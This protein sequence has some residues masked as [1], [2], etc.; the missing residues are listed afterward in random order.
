MIMK[1]FVEELI[2]KKRKRYQDDYNEML[3]DYNRELETIKGYNGRQI[4]ELLQNCDD[5]GSDEILISLDKEAQTISISNNGQPFSQKGYRS[6]FI[7]NLSSKTSKRKYIGNKGLGFRSIINWSDSIEI[8]SANL[9]LK[10]S[11]EN[12]V[13]V[14][15]EL[16]TED[17]RQAKNE[18]ENLKG[19]I[20]PIPFLSIPELQTVESDYYITTIKIKYKSEYLVDIIEQVKTI[21]PETLLFLRNIKYVKRQG[22]DGLNDIQCEKQSL[23]TDEQFKPSQKITFVES[24]VWNIFE[25]EAILP[26]QYKESNNDEDEFY[27]IKIA[28]E[29]NF[30]RTS[31]LLYSYFPTNIRLNQPYILHATFDLDSTRNQLND[32]NKNRFLLARIV[33]FT[34]KVAKFY[35]S[36]VV[37]YTPLEIL[38]HSHQADSLSKLGYY[39]KLKIAISEGCIYPCIDNTYKKKN[40]VIYVSDDFAQTLININATHLFSNHLKRLNSSKVIIPKTNLGAIPNIIDVLNKI[41]SL[42]LTHKH[43]ALFISQ[44]VKEGSFIK[45]RLINQLNLLVNDNNDIILGDEYIY[46]PITQGNELQTPSFSRIQFLNKDLYEELLVVFNYSSKDNP[47]R[48][49]FL[50]DKLSG[51][52]NIHSY[53]PATLAQKIVSETNKIIEK[54]ENNAIEKIQEMN[55]CLFYNYKKRDGNIPVMNER[56]NVPSITLNKKVKPINDLVLSSGYPTGRIT[57]LIFENIY[58]EENYIADSETLG[59]TQ[60]DDVY[61]IENYL[62]WLNVNRYAKYRVYTNVISGYSNYA[63]YIKQLKGLNQTSYSLTL[64]VIDSFYKVLEKISLE[65]LIIWI[66]FDE[67][68]KKQLNDL[69]NEDVFNN[70]YR[71]YNRISNIPTYLKYLIQS[72]YKYKFSDLLIDDDYLWS[73]DFNITYQSKEFTDNGINK[74]S[75]NEILVSLGAKDDFNQLTINKVAEIINKA[76][77]H[78]PDGKKTQSIYKKS[79]SHY[80]ENRQALVSPVELFADNGSEKLGLYAQDKVYFS[81]KIKLP[82]L[83]KKDFPIFNFPARQGGIEAIKF[84]GINDLKNLDI[85]ITTKTE[86]ERITAIF[87]EYFEKIKPL[88]LTQRISSIED[89]KQKGN[90]ANVCKNINIVLCESIT[91][92]V[93]D[94]EYGV[95]DYEFLHY[96][97]NEYYLRIKNSDT[98]DSLRKNHLFTE[99]FAEIISLSFDISGEKNEFK[100]ILQSDYEFAIENIKNEFGNDCYQEARNLLGLANHKQ[101]FWQAVFKSKEFEYEETLDDLSLEALIL[102][103]FNIEF[104]TNSIDYE[105]LED[106]TELNKVYDLFNLVQIEL[107]S[108]AS[109]YEYPIGFEKVNYFKIKNYLLSKKKTVKCSVW[110]Q[111]ESKEVEEQSLFLDLIDKYENFEGFVKEKSLLTKYEFTIDLDTILKE[112]VSFLYKDLQLSQEIDLDIVK[113]LNQEGLK[114]DELFQINQ[115]KRFKSLIYFKNAIEIIKQ[116]IRKELDEKIETSEIQVVKNESIVHPKLLDSVNLQPKIISKDYNLNKKN[117]VYIPKYVDTRKLKEIGTTSERIVYQYLLKD[118]NYKDV[119]WAGEDDEGLHHDIRY[120]DNSQRIK[121]VEV[122]TFDNGYFYLSKAEYEFGKNHKEDYEI[123]LV[124]N[125]QEIIPIRN[126]FTDGKYEAT[127]NEYI[128]Y[129]EY[130]TA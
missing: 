45:N 14:Y 35:A 89:K 4:L 9:L 82:K 123:W 37:N 33:D 111:L 34:T 66:Y 117:G 16:F 93:K 49:R 55:R 2:I 5:E 42:S 85:E 125:K 58:S 97:K 116:E 43:R 1:N 87:K 27:Q 31:P 119:Y 70:F 109:I 98:L 22:F 83:L 63:N 28:I 100:H 39:E 88:I 7:A 107:K 114:T 79:L 101:A 105:N 78:Y 71:A 3:G 77:K 62:L 118:K 32:S 20:I 74:S 54:D 21:T 124:K 41:S 81:E 129:L 96:E 67:D 8:Q 68:L 47:I 26:S 46:T 110:K 30:K 115:S 25:E 10:Y 65:R 51:F 24:S 11:E 75:I 69:K 23:I 113:N 72:R 92:K 102:S 122:K 84:F 13:K 127:P 108:F 103:K 126:F 48:S 59:F 40:E 56:I 104:S 64:K 91:Y 53:E 6:L 130:I 44:V 86:L 99:S 38:Y 61:E 73:N 112:Y 120:T 90:Q 60:N 18:E 17:F 15:N 52:C 95:S 80:K 76:P 121:Y 12:R 128:I 94:T 36:E 106:E 57:A 29:E 50:Y 19:N